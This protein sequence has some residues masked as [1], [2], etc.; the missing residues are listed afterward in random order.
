MPLCELNA[1]LMMLTSFP[2][3][4]TPAVLEGV[5]LAFQARVLSPTTIV[6]GFFGFFFFFSLRLFSTEKKFTAFVANALTKTI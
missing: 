6:G 5:S 3:L 4:P 1:D 2:Q